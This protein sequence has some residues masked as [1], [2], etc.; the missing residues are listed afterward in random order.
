[1]YQLLKYPASH[2]QYYK[3]INVAA[4]TIHQACRITCRLMYYV[5]KFL[6]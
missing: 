5:P 3:I 1:M 6:T 2:T 4:G